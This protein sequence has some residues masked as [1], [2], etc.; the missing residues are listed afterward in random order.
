MSLENNIVKT[1]WENVMMDRTFKTSILLFGLF[2]LLNISESYSAE[3]PKRIFLRLKQHT[4]EKSVFDKIQYIEGLKV[5]ESLLPPARSIT[6]NKKNLHR[7]Q[8][9]QN[10]ELYGIIKAEEPLLRTYVIEYSGGLNPEKIVR[11]LIEEYQEIELAEVRYPD[12]LLYTPNDLYVGT[13]HMLDQCNFLAAWDIYRGDTSVVIAISDNGSNNVHEDLKNNIAAFWGEIPGNGIDDDGNGYIDDYKGYN[14]TYIQDGNAADNTYNTHPHGSQTAGIAAAHFDNGIGIAGA[15]AKSRLFPIKTCRLGTTDIDYGYESI[16]YAAEQRFKVINLSWGRVKSFS[17]FDQS[18]I[19]YAVAYDLVVVAA[20]GNVDTY[21]NETYPAGYY[22]VLGVGEV[23]RYDKITS[24]SLGVQVRIMA[25]GTGNYTTGNGNSTYQNVSSGTSFSAPVIAGAVALARGKYPELKAL[26]AI[27][28][29]RQCT[30]DI[31]SKNFSDRNVIPGRL[32]V[33]KIMETNPFSIPGIK[34]NFFAF[35]NENGEIMDRYNP[36]DKIT[37]EIKAKNHLGAANNVRFVLS[38]AYDFLNII[39]IINPEVTI[40]RV[41]RES[42]FSI[43]PFKFEFSSEYTDKILLRVDIYADNDY[44]DFFLV[45][46]TPT[47]EMTTFSNDVLAFSVSDRGTFGFRIKE[48]S[49]G[50][51]DGIGFVYKKN[52]N[53]IFKGGLIV[54]EDRARTVSANYNDNGGANNDFASV[55]SFS[56]PNRNI[57]IINDSKASNKMGIQISQEYLLPEGEK[58]FTKIK[59][60]VKNIS[61]SNLNDISVAYYIDWELGP[62]GSSFEFN[63]TEL[64]QDAIPESFAAYP[65]ACEIAEYTNA[66]YPLVGMLVFT[67]STVN[68]QAQAAGLTYK[69]TQTFDLSSQLSALYNGTNIQNDEITDISVLVGMRFLGE[70]LPDDE[71]DCEFCLA[72]ADTKNDI[73]RLMHECVLGVSVD[74]KTAHEPF[75]S[76]FPQPAADF[77]VINLPGNEFKTTNLAIYDVNSNKRY[78]YVIDNMPNFYTMSINELASGVYFLK[79]SCGDKIYTKKF[80]IIR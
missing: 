37:L 31:T 27:E 53:Q 7:A 15:G 61:N 43:L 70:F 69:E 34:P 12:E 58:S 10:S 2:L 19:D 44:H 78:D 64:L 65:A 48:D 40:N 21:T 16:M 36:G 76:V 54:G 74:D 13:Q 11:K 73:I 79:I 63:R 50:E 59:L 8:L 49:G 66:Q 52:R 55:K 6:H 51:N 3:N 45:P 60:K 5:V 30:D 24:T 56:F 41:E 17:A 1:L 22:G 77:L 35:K 46:F 28:F 20:G 42:E 32:N 4:D 9:L 14:F 75:I 33:L 62:T 18:I 47:V 67:N 71:K 38:K 23:D 39:N 57:G 68:A 29:V 26:Q 25:P 80:S 72:V